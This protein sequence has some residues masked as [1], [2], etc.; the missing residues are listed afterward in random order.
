[1][2]GLRLHLHLGFDAAHTSNGKSGPMRLRNFESY[3]EYVSCQERA[4]TAKLQT[5]WASPAT[6]LFIAAQ[7][8]ARI[9]KAKFGICHGVRN[10]WEV[11][12]LRKLLG[13]EIIGTDIARTASRFP[14]VI[15][16]DF[17]EVKEE[18]IGAVDFIYS[19]SLDHAYDPSLCIRNWM[20]CLSRVGI[21]FVEWTP[22]HASPR[23]WTADCFTAELQEYV[24]LATGYTV[25]IEAMDDRRHTHVLMITRG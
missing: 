15:K 21:C 3:E 10:G 1:M 7:V 14:N 12:E 5:V 11:N 8:R 22:V 9:P 19:N 13:I 23:T 25:E 18:W 17:H 24:S 6:I 16:W 2:A 20:K 4:N